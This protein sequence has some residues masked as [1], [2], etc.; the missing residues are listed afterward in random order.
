MDITVV[1]VGGSLAEKPESLHVL[2]KKLGELSLKQSLVVVGG[3]GEFADVARTQDKRFNLSAFT[4]HRMAILGMDAYGLLLADLTPNSCIVDS[5]EDAEQVLSEGKLAVFLPSCF[6]FS[7]DPLEN[8]WDATSDAITACIA[9]KLEA[10]KILLLTD[11]DGIYNVDPKKNRDAKLIQKITPKELL[12]QNQR[13]SVDKILPKL[14]S[15]SKIPCFVLNGLYSERIE[16]I[17]KGQKTIY[18]LIGGVKI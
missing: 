9:E 13:S 7:A 2:C 10:K 17:L 16:A 18:T 4:S 5:F 6:M 1:K 14:L 3:G 11:V 15:Q 8:S 12:A